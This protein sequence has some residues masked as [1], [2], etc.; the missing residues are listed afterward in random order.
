V[1]NNKGFVTGVQAVL[2]NVLQDRHMLG[3]VGIVGLTWAGHQ[4]FMAMQQT[5]NVIHG[6]VETR[7]WLRQR[8]TAIGA[9]IGTLVVLMV[10]IFV[11]A[12]YARLD[13]HIGSRIPLVLHVIL[14]RSVAVIIPTVMMWGLFTALYQA[15]PACSVP[16]R[17][18]LV[19]GVVAA[20]LWHASLLGFGVY[21]QYSHGYDRLYGP[22]A[23]LAILV[24][25]CYYSMAILL[26]GAEITA[27]L[28]KKP[29]S[30]PDVSDPT[31]HVVSSN[32]NIGAMVRRNM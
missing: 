8:I 21:L 20:V 7:H 4:V 3:V 17:Y 1:P 9:A 11:V 19:G 25:W 28:N 30:V 13:G 27:D 22:L 18:A 26:L 29:L 10:D 16:H 31:A 14:T 24:V 15:L 12:F 32:N 23:G 6:T 5:M 2:D